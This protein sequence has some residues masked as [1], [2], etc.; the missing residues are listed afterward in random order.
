MLSKKMEKALNEQ[1]EKEFF[2]SHLYLSM[3]AYFAQKNLSGFAN[4]FNIQAQEERDHAML[5][6]NYV[7]RTGGKVT[8]TKIDAPKVDFDS[9]IDVLKETLVHEEFITKSIY[10]LV[11]AAQE[12]RDHKTIQY[13]KWFVDEQVE[14]EENASDN[15]AKYELVA[16]DGKGLYM[17]DSE[18]GARVY[19]PITSINGSGN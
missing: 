4:W 19:T 1:I 9:D 14:E 10:Q 2:S 15:I 3:S 13:L 7:I 16:N 6:F 18:L 12:E 8:L 5:L 17:L 11:D